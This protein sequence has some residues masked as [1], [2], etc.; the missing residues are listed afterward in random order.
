MAKRDYYEILGVSKDAS[1][2]EIKKA[3][4]K[5]AMKYHPDR[6]PD[7]KEAEEKFKEAA[8]A[9]E[10]LSDQQKRQQ[11]DQFGH[12]GAQG[13]GG[14]AGFHNM[15]DIF[16]N[17]G[18]IFSDIFGGGGARRGHKKSGPTPKRGHDLAKEVAITLE[19]AF[20][21]TK[22]D[23]TYYH[24]TNC[25][26]C[27]G[28]GTQSGTKAEECSDC[29]GTGQ[30]RYQAGIFIQTS[31]CPTCN[32]QGFFIK[33]PCKTC[34]GQSR[35]QKY[36]TISVTIPKGIFDGA[37]LRVAG[38][39][40]AGVYGGSSG[41]LIVHVSIMPHK[42][43]ERVGDNLECTVTLTYPQLVFGAHIDIKNIDSSKETLKVPKGCAIGERIVIKDKGFPKLRSRHRGDLIVTT[44]CDIPKSLSNKA[45]ETLRKYSEQIGT[46]VD[47]NAGGIAGFFK[48][49]LG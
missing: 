4:R 44:N 14:G 45:D 5:L 41:D 21:G 10:I 20:S 37:N 2:D 22:K 17:F 15:E 8:E 40:D 32:G 18:D 25:K 31:S 27:S 39:G 28:K 48:K 47:S 7:N 3:Y 6:N 30:V 35:I 19:D 46:D 9:Y 49:F 33:N 24:F 38:K 26:D 12:A 29:H 23:V 34:N 36:E 43:F 42:T 13:M 16:A 1:A 11:Y